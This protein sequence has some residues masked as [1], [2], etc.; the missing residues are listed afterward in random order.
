MRWL[1]QF[2]FFYVGLFAALMVFMMAAYESAH[3]ANCVIYLRVVEPRSPASGFG[4]CANDRTLVLQIFRNHAT[5]NH[6]E[7]SEQRLPAV[8]AEIMKTRAEKS[9]FVWADREIEF[10]R[11]A[12]TLGKVQ[13]A[14]PDLRFIVLTD[15]DLNNPGWCVRYPKDATGREFY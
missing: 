11:F 7:I 3:V 1:N 15:D 8:V 13:A 14:V 2:S 5:I 9:L 6:G 12:V 10:E 4:N